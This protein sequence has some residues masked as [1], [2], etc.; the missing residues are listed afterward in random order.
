MAR[1]HA[2]AVRAEVAAAVADLQRRP[3]RDAW[4]WL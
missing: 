4:A 3:W 2:E 1:P